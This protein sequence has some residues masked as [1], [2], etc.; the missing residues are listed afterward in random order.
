MVSG[1]IRNRCAS[2]RP[3]EE[4][5]LFVF[6]RMLAMAGEIM[7]AWTTYGCY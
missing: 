7:D 4:E 1:R 3:G 5:I 2:V 6:R